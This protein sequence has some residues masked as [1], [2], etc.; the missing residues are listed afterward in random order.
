MELIIFLD[1][2]YF[3]IFYKSLRAIIEITNYL[4]NFIVGMSIKI[5][6]G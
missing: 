4:H 2:P 3:F 1:P 6:I 5:E